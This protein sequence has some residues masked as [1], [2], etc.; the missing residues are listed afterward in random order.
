MQRKFHGHTCSPRRLPSFRR[1]NGSKSRGE[2]IVSRPTAGS[3]N[4]GG[5]GSSTPSSRQSRCSHHGSS[6][7]RSRIDRDA[8]LSFPGAERAWLAVPGRSYVVAVL[9][10]CRLQLTMPSSGRAG[11]GSL[12]GL[13]SPDDFSDVPLGPRSSPLQ[14]C[15]RRIP[16]RSSRAGRRY[17]SPLALGPHHSDQGKNQAGQDDVGSPRLAAL[18]GLP[19]SHER[20]DY[21]CYEVLA[22]E[23]LASCAEHRGRGAA[24]ALWR[25]PPPRADARRPLARGPWP[26]LRPAPDGNQP[27]RAGHTGAA[28]FDDRAT[29]ESASALSGG[30][31]SGGGVIR[32]SPSEPLAR[33]AYGSRRRTGPRLHGFDCSRDAGPFG[34]T[35][36]G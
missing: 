30:A 7:S 21:R 22:L 25:Q 31:A 27:A 35:G 20:Q 3:E 13:G 32:A 16:V 8:G 2:L 5:S 6:Q 12:G 4:Q 9:T 17:R 36:C 28:A 23:V 29:C 18:G 11:G 19:R 10:Q 24:R 15:C 1:L 33:R 26:R 14:G 34:T